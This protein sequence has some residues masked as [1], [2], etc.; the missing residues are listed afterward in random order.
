[1]GL[2]GLSLVYL[3]AG[4]SRIRHKG[5]CHLVACGNL[6]QFSNRTVSETS[7]FLLG[8]LKNTD[9]YVGFVL[10]ILKIETQYNF[11]RTFG[12]SH[13]TIHGQDPTVLLMNWYDPR[14]IQS[15][16]GKV[17]FALNGKFRKG[18]DFPDAY[19]NGV[20]FFVVNKKPLSQNDVTYR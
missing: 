4:D 17:F 13:G 15:G 8:Q 16:E 7:R 1:M 10:R 9:H 11:K 5:S 12:I 18:N 14:L 6:A 20:R 2:Y 3:P 19:K